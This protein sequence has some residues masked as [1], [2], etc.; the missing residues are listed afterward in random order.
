M[1]PPV[2]Q[3]SGFTGLQAT[4][5]MSIA[6]F[7]M[8]LAALLLAA[9]RKEALEDLVSLGALSAATFLL[10]SALLIARY[11]G[12]SRLSFALG[13]RPTHPL[14][15][16]LGL[17]GGIVAQI[18]ADGILAAIHHYFPA[19]QEQTLAR[20]EMM[21]PHGVGHGIALVVV[22]AIV[23]PLAEEAF[24]RGAVYGALRRSGRSGARAAVYTGIGFTLC[25]FDP[26]TLLPI[27]LVAAYLGT[28]RVVSG[29]LWPSVMAHVGFNGLTMLSAVSGYGLS[30]DF[31]VSPAVQIVGALGLASIVWMSYRLGTRSPRALL[32]R[33]EE[34]TA[35]DD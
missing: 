24:F 2:R 22:L 10:T 34:E 1:R 9:F 32:S 27:G 4:L 13:F 18:P 31:L 30:V 15:M 23:V 6:F 21:K 12:G 5:W 28:L 3:S 16:P 26:T 33:T 17:L 8:V 19:T 20:M 7:W 35:T 29:S 14:L 11:P 25:H